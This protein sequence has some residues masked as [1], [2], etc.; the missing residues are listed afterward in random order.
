MQKMK[1]FFLVD[2]M[3]SIRFTSKIYNAIE[4]FDQYS[5]DVDQ[6]LSK[7]LIKSFIETKYKVK[8]IAVNTHRLPYERKTSYY[9]NNGSSSRVVRQAKRA[10]ITLQK[11]DV[12][13]M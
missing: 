3:K 2:Q 10:I 12:L 5:F 11:G 8:V 9:T 6:R 7:P 13:P 1:P 4:L